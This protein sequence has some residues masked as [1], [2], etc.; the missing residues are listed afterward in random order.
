MIYVTDKES[1]VFEDPL[2]MCSVYSLY[3]K[4]VNFFLEYL[5]LTKSMYNDYLNLSANKSV[6]NSVKLVKYT[7]LVYYNYSLCSRC[8]A[9]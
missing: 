2:L 9:H 4:E 7:H 5:A 1:I 3:P 6:V 8:S